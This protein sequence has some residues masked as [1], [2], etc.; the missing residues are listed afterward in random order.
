MRVVPDVFTL[1]D[2]RVYCIALGHEDL[3]DRNDLRRNPVL[4]SILGRLEARRA[5]RGP[6]GRQ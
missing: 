3:G 6:F 1:V 2:P 5:N 4:G